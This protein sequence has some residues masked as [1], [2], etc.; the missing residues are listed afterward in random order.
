MRKPRLIPLVVSSLGYAKF[1]RWYGG[2]STPLTADEVDAA[3][4]RIAETARQNGRA[5]IPELLAELRTV[6]VPEG[7]D[8]GREFVMV[9]L[10]RYRKKAEY[11]PGSPYGDDPMAAD[12]RY[13]QAVIPELLKRGSWPI[14]HG[15]VAGRFIHPHGNDDWDVVALVRYR[16]RRDM[17][18]MAMALAEKNADIHKWASIEKTQV[19]PVKA[20]LSLFAG[21]FLAGAL[22]AGAALAGTAL[23]GRKRS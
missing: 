10:I 3:L 16:S 15:K 8:D 4:S 12:K 6:L 5:P 7:G 14:F 17:L 22:F 21:R 11:P 18:G 2:S 1:L 23:L 13:N 9:N 20:G 19:F